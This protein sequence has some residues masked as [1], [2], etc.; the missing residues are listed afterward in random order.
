MKK[1]KNTTSLCYKYYIVKFR[2]ACSTQIISD[3]I[4]KHMHARANTSIRASHTCS[5]DNVDRN[6]T[7]RSIGHG[8]RSYFVFTK[9][10]YL[11]CI[12]FCVV[13]SSKVM[14]SN[15]RFSV[16][17]FV[18]PSLSLSPALHRFDAKNRRTDRS[19]KRKKIYN[20]NLYISV[21]FFPSKYMWWSRMNA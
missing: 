13:I 19:G 6:R 7:L 20:K 12:L 1:K 8:W 15:S 17:A 3:V 5:K 10:A 11:W 16:P 2:F 21:F 4:L 18:S 14:C 9:I